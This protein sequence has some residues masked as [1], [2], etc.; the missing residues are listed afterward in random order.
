MEDGE[1]GQMVSGS[2]STR[3]SLG[4]SV[5]CQARQSH[6]SRLG[7]GPEPSATAAYLMSREAKRGM[8]SLNWSECG[9]VAAPERNL[10]AISKEITVFR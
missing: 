4:R 5:R 2:D 8:Q 7:S 9:K 10:H 1:E 3:G 6:A